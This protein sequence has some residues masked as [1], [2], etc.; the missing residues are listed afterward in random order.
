MHVKSSIVENSTVEI[1]GKSTF[2]PEESA[3]NKTL[4][5]LLHGVE[6]MWDSRDTGAERK[7]VSAD[8]QLYFTKYCATKTQR[9][10]RIGVVFVRSLN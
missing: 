5:F 7:C 1:T 2:H 8:E 9:L 3:E 10:K 4:C 6:R